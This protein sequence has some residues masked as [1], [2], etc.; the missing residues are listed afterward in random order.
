MTNFSIEYN[1]YLVNCLFKKNGKE[2]TEKSKV[3]AKSNQRLQVL[4]GESVNWK[5]L[6]AE[7]ANV[8]DDDEVAIHF[9][10]RKID[11]DDLQYTFDLYEGP[12]KF[13][14]SFTESKNDADV[15]GELDGIFNDIREKNLP[16]FSAKN[17]EGKDI[18]A[19]Y[20]EVKN[21]IFEVS[22]IATMSSGKSTLINSLLH[23]ELLPS[24]NKACTATI[25]EILDND[26]MDH[27][28]AE[29][30][31][32]DETVVY[33]RQEVTI[34][35]MKKYNS[36]ERVTYI[37][38]EGSVPEIP[39][40]KIRLCLR[41][42]PGPNNSRD[43]NHEKLTKSIIKRT[44]AVVLYVMN[45][46]QLGIKD[47]EQLLRDI[48]DAMKRDGKQSRD[49][50]IFVINKCDELDEGKGETLDKTLNDVQEYLKKFN[51]VEP[52]IIPTSARLALL[53]RKKR[54]GEKLTRKENDDLNNNIKYF[55]DDEVLH[56]ERFATLTPTTREKLQAQVKTYHANEEEEDL[57]ALIHTGVP[58]VEATICEY[59]E[60]YAYPM[61]INDAI[62][63]IDSILKELDMKTKF[64]KSIASDG[65]K[66][67]KVRKQIAEAKKRH[68]E[69]KHV[70][71]CYKEKISQFKLDTLDESD[72]RYGV[73]RELKKMLQPYNREEAVDKIEADS[74][75]SLF[76][77]RLVQY[78]RECESKLNSE[79]D[80]KIFYKCK[81][82]LNEYTLIIQSILDDIEIEGFDFKKISKFNKIEIPNIYDIKTRNEQIRYRSETRWKDNPE[83]Q[84]FLGFFKFWEPRQI[85][86]T[87]SV[88]DG[89]NVNVWKVV[90]DIMSVFSNSI[91][92]NISSMFEQAE[93]QIKEYK[94]VFSENIDILD[95]EITKILEQLDKDTKKSEELEKRV[96]ENQELASWVEQK[97][98]EIREL[99]TF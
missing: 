2:L 35:E 28:E 1:P 8:C 64:E 56:F 5:G 97:E 79:I 66:L 55:V 15:I 77:Q 27:Y 75:I 46:T 24:E 18:F 10:G 94:K 76:Q 83:R 68:A 48:S 62:K 69:S 29:C 22:V 33:P 12:V 19:A 65:E 92:I 78:Q 86:Y 50:F 40:D 63:D 60:K 14:L 72:T 54:K 80:S 61:K 21:G 96:K 26:D 20:E 17:N 91:K 85:S 52:T 32:A 6:P 74:K 89:I 38:I 16:E 42:T 37:N 70:Y 41:D 45:A 36:D 67:A 51:I 7:I 99:L 71:D 93:K 25:C 59:I 88:R 34:D 98:R 53:I 47:D 49:R 43:E 30:Y 82:I 31:A 73:D 84:G 23:T 13:E 4:L 39:S 87:V 11:F 3:G 95:S 44:N 9:K 81:E 90:T 57:E 58:A